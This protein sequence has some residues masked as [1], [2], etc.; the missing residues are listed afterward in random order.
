MFWYKQDRPLYDLET[1]KLHP[2]RFPRDVSSN[3]RGYPLHI[4][5]TP[6]RQEA[7]RALRVSVQERIR[8]SLGDSP[9][10]Q[11]SLQRPAPKYEVKHEQTRHGNDSL[12]EF[13]YECLDASI[14]TD[15]CNRLPFSVL[16]P[17]QG[18][19]STSA[20]EKDVVI[21]FPPFSNN[22][23]RRL[24]VE[25]SK[26]VT[27]GA[28]LVRLGFIVLVPSYPSLHD[29]QPD[30]KRAGFSTHLMKAIDDAVALSEFSK[31]LPE[32]YPDL[33]IGLMGHSL[34]GLVALHA[35]PFIEQTKAIISSAGFH[36][37]DHF[38]IR[39]KIDMSRAEM[40]PFMRSKSGLFAP[41]EFSEII[42]CMAPTPIFLST[43]TDDKH[44]P[45]V[46]ISAARTAALGVYR[47]LDA[48]SSL[49][50][51]VDNSQHV[52]SKSCRTKAYQM[53]FEAMTRSSLDVDKALSPTGAS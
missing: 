9:Y 15:A 6:S 51:G 17:G 11:G 46:S 29:Y 27:V 37:I 52:F 33:K 48:D 8:H 39:G 21:I 19:L 16:K 30:L 38:N 12:G 13:S 35:A 43:N 26:H 24:I 7:I 40:L 18:C 36:C 53:L 23:G 42:A 3:S 31:T 4:V 49:Q 14:Q 5:T 2:I 20:K 25:E 28:E 34:G 32:V 1:L 50:L 22:W 10:L 41:Y 44:F 47:S 45:Y